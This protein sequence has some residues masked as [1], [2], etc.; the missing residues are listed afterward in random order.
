MALNTKK[1]RYVLPT[2][3][4]FLRVVQGTILDNLRNGNDAVLNLPPLVERAYT[5][6]NETGVFPYRDFDTSVEIVER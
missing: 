6:V 2:G 4:D 3:P 5:I 1:L